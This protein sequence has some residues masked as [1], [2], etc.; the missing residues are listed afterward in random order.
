MLL[1]NKQNYHKTK[2][3]LDLKRKITHCTHN[4]FLQFYYT[5]CYMKVVPSAICLLWDIKTVFNERVYTERT[6]LMKQMY[7]KNPQCNNEHMI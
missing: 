7:Q 3:I 2:I 1:G 4:S 6:V 5:V